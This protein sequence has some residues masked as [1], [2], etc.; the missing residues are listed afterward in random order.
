MH[1]PIFCLALVVSEGGG[2]WEREARTTGVDDMR[3]SRIDPG[4]AAGSDSRTLPL[5]PRCGTRETSD[6]EGPVLQ[7]CSV[8]QGVNA[9]PCL[10]NTEAGLTGSPKAG[11][12]LLREVAL[13]LFSTTRGRRQCWPHR[14]L[15]QLMQSPV[16]P[17]PP[18]LE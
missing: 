10:E 11:V 2:G 6:T 1:A 4:S 13:R 8:S 9:C 3:L 12:R 17:R 18:V 5:V 14:L 16:P 15:G 7:N